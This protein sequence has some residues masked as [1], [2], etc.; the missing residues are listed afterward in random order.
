MKPGCVHLARAWL[1]ALGLLALTAHAV[2][3]D[4]PWPTNGPNEVCGSYGT[5]EGGGDN[6]HDGIDILGTAGTTKT[7]AVAAGTIIAVARQNNSINVYVELDPAGSQKFAVYV[8]CEEL[9]ATDVDYVNLYNGTYAAGFTAVTGTHLNANQKF[10]TI[11]SP[12]NAVTT[13][14]HVHF[15]YQDGP[16]QHSDRLNPLQQTIWA[17]AGSGAAPVNGP[18]YFKTQA[19]AYLTKATTKALTGK[20][21]VIAQMTDDMGHNEPQANPIADGDIWEPPPAGRWGGIT[22]SPWS[23]DFRVL[24][25]GGA[26]VWQAPRLE[27]TGHPIDITNLLE[28]DKR[29]QL[30]P[31]YRYCFNLTNITTG[32]QLQAATIDAA[33]NWNTKLKTGQAWNGL[34]AAR[35]GEAR[36]PDDNYTVTF[37]SEDIIHFQETSQT[38]VVNNFNQTV[39]S[40]GGGGFALADSRGGGSLRAEKATAGEKN[41]FLVG[42]GV[43]VT[44]SDYQPNS[45]Y[46]AYIFPDR[47]W[48]TQVSLA[49]GFVAMAVVTSDANGDIPLSLVW[50]S[51]AA[52]MYDIVV[53]YGH[54]HPGNGV[55]DPPI[56]GIAIDGLDDNDVG[57]AGFVVVVSPPSPSMEDVPAVSPWGLVALTLLIGGAG[58]LVL[59]RHAASIT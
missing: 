21:D 19:G 27:F 43:C 49:S 50:P 37:R 8:H 48:S 58:W 38:A 10:A 13:F 26:L 25:P 4:W 7:V 36:F 22:S 16:T 24:K 2:H 42:E 45:S 28:A 15:S 14:P 30:D 18:F 23:V 1:A 35:N 29:S 55:Y 11:A 53:D 57:T 3:A 6:F 47:N 51:A 20:V 59:R 31:E 5:Y 41:L 34:D 9:E 46:N 12:A 44:G 33:G 17:D 39:D 40:K 56:G 32:G 52:G 54:P